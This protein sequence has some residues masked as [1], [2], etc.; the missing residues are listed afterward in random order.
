M[1]RNSSNSGSVSATHDDG[2]FIRAFKF[3]GADDDTANNNGDAF[4]FTADNRR[5]TP[6]PPDAIHFNGPANGRVGRAVSPV[7]AAP[8]DDAQFADADEDA[9]N[10]GPTNG[11]GS[12]VVRAVSPARR[13]VSPARRA[14]SPARRAVSPARAAPAAYRKPDMSAPRKPSAKEAAAGLS[15]EH[16]EINAVLKKYRDDSAS[17]N[18]LQDVGNISNFYKTKRNNAHFLKYRDYAHE[19]TPGRKVPEH[20]S[21]VFEHIDY[22]DGGNYPLQTGVRDEEKDVAY[23]RHLYFAMHSTFGALCKVI[24]EKVGAENSVNACKAIQRIADRYHNPPA[25]TPTAIPGL[26]ELPA[27]VAARKDMCCVGTEVWRTS[28]VIGYLAMFLHNIATAID[29]TTE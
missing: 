2:Q 22:T 13:A 26:R 5:R 28:H 15:A 18:T 8:H 25:F 6:L 17:K 19:Q 20:F 10:N 9:A 24:E 27:G 21:I 1:Q 29:N 4:G 7:R 16:A 11:A 14:V 3:G 12:R 23:E